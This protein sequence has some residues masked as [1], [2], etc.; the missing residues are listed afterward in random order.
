MPFQ[1]LKSKMGTNGLMFE[2]HYSHDV[3]EGYAALWDSLPFLTVVKPIALLT[4]GCFTTQLLRFKLKDFL[5]NKASDSG[6]N[7]SSHALRISWC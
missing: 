1:T 4:L 2:Q 5:L 6:T 3:A 7:Y